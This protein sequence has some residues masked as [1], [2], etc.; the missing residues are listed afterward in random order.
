M[1]VFHA[2]SIIFKL[3]KLYLHLL[4]PGQWWGKYS[5]LPMGKH[6]QWRERVLSLS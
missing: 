3:E 6:S 4:V 5:L 1:H 2:E